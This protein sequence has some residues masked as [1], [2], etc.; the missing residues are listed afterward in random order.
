MFK[1]L[2]SYI[3]PSIIVLLGAVLA[4]KNYSSGTFLTGWDN[5]HPEFN[6]LLNIKRSFFALWQEYQGVGLLGGMAHAAD[7]PRQI[8]LWILSF[9]V[10][11][12]LLRYSWTFLMLILGPLGV[13]FFMKTLLGN[14][15]K[16]NFGVEISAFVSSIFYLFNLA[17][18][19]T[20]FTPFETFVSFY[21]FLPWLL[22]YAVGYLKSGERKDIAWYALVSLIA[23]SAFYVQTL[24]VVYAIFLLIFMLE[25]VLKLKKSGL[26]RCIKLWIVTFCI[27]AFWLLP[28]IYFSFAGSQIPGN[29]KINS[30]ATVETQLMNQARGTFTDIVSLKGYWFDYYDFGLDGTYDYLY[31]NWID[32]TQN[33]H[34]VQVFMGLFVISLVGFV[35]VLFRKKFPFKISG[36]L[37]LLVSYFMLA[38]TNPPFGAGYTFLS[39]KIPLFAEMFRNAYTKWSIPAAFTYSV[40]I[41][42]FIYATTFLLKGKLKYLVIFPMLVTILG[43]IYSV[44]PVFDGQLVSERVKVQ[45]PVEYFQVF[46]FFGAQPDKGRI[47]YLPFYNFW[48]WEFYKW[49]YGGSGFLWYG[50]ENP[51]LDRAFDVWSPYNESFFNEASSALYKYQIGGGEETLTKSEEA[52]RV[53]SNL[54]V[55]QE[56]ENILSKYQ[57]RYLLLDE[58]IINPGGSANL[59]FI[60]GIKE[61]VAGSQ[62][63]KEK[64]HFGALTVYEFMGQSSTG[65]VVVPETY[66]SLDTNLTYSKYDPMY[67]KYGDYISGESET[68]F[69][70]TNFDSRGDA[71]ISVGEDQLVFVNDQKRARV[72]LPTS[73]KI[74]ETFPEAQ[75][76]KEGYNCDLKK[77]GEVVKERLDNGNFY[78]AYN[79]GVSCDWFYYPDVKYNQAYVL[80]L[81][82][83]NITGRSLKFYLQNVKTKRMDLE[84]LLD[85]GDFDSYYVIYPTEANTGVEEEDLGYTLNVETRSFSKIASENE[86]QVIEFIP[87]DIDFLQNLTIKGDEPQITSNQVKV[88]HVGK[89]GTVLYKVKVEKTNA[90]ETG[91]VVLG[92]GYDN[93]WLAFTRDTQNKS[94]KKLAHVQVN[95]WANGWVIPKVLDT[96][97]TVVIFYWPQ[98]LEWGGL[99]LILPVIFILSRRKK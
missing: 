2:K 54:K 50:I 13:F 23:T 57:V 62:N 1:K 86:I 7:L 43:C 94:F 5:L 72:F 81:K 70:F 88:T 58:N 37:M 46:D 82:G 91:L 53:S 48:G 95:G 75:G 63:I 65:G 99:V 41:G 79:G 45:I 12:E 6:L 35:L 33:P 59:L 71:K 44:K 49:G 20:F 56:F 80:H 25:S 14:Q 90:G 69:P 18:V 8:F 76:Y 36:P 47:A 22:R 51:I 24:F 61:V 77:K 16:A 84:E 42:F 93:G 78:G 40:G 67:Q 27:N 9:G 85:V 97:S 4:V 83:K 68:V 73:N 89:W 28:V 87:F 96:S 60:P 55:T 64:T 30:I 26:V 98:L 52:E 17:T 32:Y 10:P 39:D 19:Q 29:S 34:V 66:V 38:T 21:G 92:Q 3:F 74:F 15:K 31:K 11:T